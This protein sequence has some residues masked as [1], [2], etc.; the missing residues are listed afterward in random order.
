MPELPEVEIVKQ[1]LLKK[2]K[3]KKIQKVIIKNGNLRFKI[4]QNFSTILKNSK[5]KNIS[6]F[7]KYLII[8]LDNNQYCIIHLGMSGTLHIIEKRKKKLFTN[9][10]FYHSP[11]L[12]K[13]HNHVYIFFDKFKLVYNDP[14]RFGFIRL[15]EDKDKLKNFLSNYGPEPFDKTFNLSYLKIKL[16]N[17]SKNIKNYL[18][19]QKFVSGIG[20]IYASEILFLS[21]INP[22]KKSGRLTVKDHKK[23]I[24]FSKVVLKKAIIK[25]G[26]TIQN[27]KNSY[28]KPGSF[29][30]HFKVYDR[31]GKKCLIKRC[32]GIV[33]KKIISNRSSFYCNFCQKI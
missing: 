6:R 13:K 7:S 14:R 21:K 20:N 24:L 29:Q 18:L 19:D 27:F 10:S 23:I 31:E 3:Y 30:K 11:K 12:P 16:N 2:I 25:G 26:S 28:G 33:N 4:A 17:K 22:L 32:K 15:I 5:I 8:K 1:S 9:L